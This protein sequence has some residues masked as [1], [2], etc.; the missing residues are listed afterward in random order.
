MAFLLE[1]LLRL[2]GGASAASKQLSIPATGIRKWWKRRLVYNSFL[3]VFFVAYSW[4]RASAASHCGGGG[5][6]L[7]I[8]F[9]SHFRA[10]VRTPQCGACNE[11]KTGF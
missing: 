3:L 9:Y 6:I 5:L 11:F 8:L 4:P 7:L 1:L 10:A 2:R